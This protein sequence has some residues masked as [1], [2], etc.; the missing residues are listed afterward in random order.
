MQGVILSAGL[1][2]RLSR[3]SNGNPKCLVPI[4]GKPLIMHQLE[5]LADN[6]VGQVVM[7]LGHQADAVRGVVGDRVEYIVNPIYEQ[8]NSLYSLW[9]AREWIQGPFVLLNSDLFFHPDIIAR[10]LEE[11]GNVLAF[12]STSSRGTEQ[13]KVAIRERR[14]ADLGKD[15]PIAS[16][17]GESLGLIRFDAEGARVVLAQADELTKSGHEKA[18]VTEALRRA[19]REVPIY[20]MNIAGLPWVE[21]DFPHDLEEAR[22]EVWPAI[23][24]SRWKGIVLWKRT[25][26]IALGLAAGLLALSGWMA[27]AEL[28]PASTEWETVKPKDADKV[29]LRTGERSQK[30]WLVEPDRPV[31]VEVEGSK[32]VRVDSRFLQHASASFPPKCVLEVAVDHKPE[33]WVVVNSTVDPETELAGF[34][35]GERDRLQFGLP[36]GPH[37]MKLSLIAGNCQR[38]LIRVRQQE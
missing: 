33:N 4:G 21:V 17:R 22:K 36:A 35:L 12:D 5:A 23:K 10:L 37:V 15:L 13:T 16:A 19:C 24:K 3:L 7:V 34:V 29:L 26:W 30:W 6:G 31:L 25:R 8:T 38:V 18:W 27:S 2:S 11:E 28:G 1:G 32:Q 20:G 14:V 9:L